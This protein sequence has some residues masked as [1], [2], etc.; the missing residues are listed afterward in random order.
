MIEEIN[1]QIFF[2]KS[3]LQNRGTPTQCVADENIGRNE[4]FW[5]S[6]PKKVSET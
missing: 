1:N 6:S 5:G 4:K 3:D 2:F